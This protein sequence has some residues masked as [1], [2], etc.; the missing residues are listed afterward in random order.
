ML[1]KTA[2]MLLLF[3]RIT[4]CVTHQ[5]IH[6][7]FKN[8]S[9]KPKIPF[10][11]SLAFAASC[12]GHLFAIFSIGVKFSAVTSHFMSQILDQKLLTVGSFHQNEGLKVRCFFPL[13]RRGVKAERNVKYRGIIITRFGSLSFFFFAIN[14]S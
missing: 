4:F 13:R 7:R 11:G 1:A 5:T 3:D 2:P 12:R 9:Q 14:P 6:H 10:P 8:P